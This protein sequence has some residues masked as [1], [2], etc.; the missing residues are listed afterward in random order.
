MRVSANS[1]S[2]VPCVLVI[3]HFEA[4]GDFFVESTPRVTVSE[5]G[6]LRV[7]EDSF[8]PVPEFWIS[9]TVGAMLDFVFDAFHQHYFFFFNLVTVDSVEICQGKKYLYGVIFLQYASE[10]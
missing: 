4:S 1:S 5:M 2:H 6:L 9:K 7:G 8:S 3:G 10:S